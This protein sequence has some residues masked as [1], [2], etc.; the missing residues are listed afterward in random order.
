MWSGPSPNSVA[1]Y[2][3]KESAASL[4]KERF[5]NVI[6]SGKQDQYRP[7]YLKCGFYLWHDRIFLTVMFLI[8]KPALKENYKLE[9]S[10][11]LDL[12]LTILLP[13]AR[14]WLGVIK[15]EL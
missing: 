12:R 9:C 11:L 1:F 7:K 10:F 14:Q 15:G 4:Q 5:G 8:W 6:S 2:I 13:I 3:E